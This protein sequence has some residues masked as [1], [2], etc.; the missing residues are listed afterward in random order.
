M[1]L[2]STCRINKPKPVVMN[3]LVKVWITGSEP[4]LGVMH[5]IDKADPT[6]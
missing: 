6:F 3:E 4:E 1:A 2:T 5:E